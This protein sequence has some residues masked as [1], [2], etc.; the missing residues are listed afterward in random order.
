MRPSRT[1][2]GSAYL[3]IVGATM[4]VAV[5]GFA[6][7]TAARVQLR[8]GE[9]GGD[10]QAARANARSGIQL[11]RLF[12]ERESDWRTKRPS[13]VWL[14][15]LALDKAGGAVT[16]EV[17][18]PTDNNLAN[19]D[20]DPVVIT[21]TGF[22]G[23]AMQV[24]R[25]TL[26]PR[27]AALDCLN[28][29]ALADGAFTVNNGT[30]TCDQTVATNSN[31][32]TAG[33]SRIDCRVEAVGLISGSGYLGSRV[34]DVPRRSVPDEQ[35]VFDTYLATATWINYGNLATGVMQD[36]V[37]SPQNNPYGATTNPQGIYA[38][39]CAGRTFV[40]RNARVVGTLILV[41][42]RADSRVEGAVNVAPAAAN[43]PCLLVRGSMSF[44]YG[45]SSLVEGAGRNF[46]PPG[47]P[48]NGTANN[49][50]TDSYPSQVRGLAY[51]TGGATL[52]C[53]GRFE[54]VFV[55]GGGMS[56]Q[57]TLVLTYD[58]T[59]ASN[60]PAAFG[61]APILVPLPGSMARVVR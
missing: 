56:G 37:L 28:V 58:P 16:V 1:R 48:Y 13:G 54:G 11:A 6:A 5:I 42:P 29:T 2:H 43:F 36:V 55:C 14:N 21:A 18:D 25:V 34:T 15:R 32:T 41:N 39:D 10:V 60:P 40:L 19:F 7:V 35:L 3:A 23:A 30:L 57:G 9:R 51:I 38:I 45:S 31:F 59:Y 26:V 12:I 4:L 49:T 27:R 20:T 50:V 33:A 46:N 44:L 53:Q 22:A 47:T 61:D 8:T 17:T 24:E 52:N